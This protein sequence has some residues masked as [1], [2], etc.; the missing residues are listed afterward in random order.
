VKR[1]LALPTL[2]AALNK[3][4]RSTLISGRVATSPG[5][6]TA[7]LELRLELFGVLAHGA[8][9]PLLPRRQ[10]PAIFC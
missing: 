4:P 7:M 8:G 1:V 5:E 9:A 6:L 3:I 2:H 10:G